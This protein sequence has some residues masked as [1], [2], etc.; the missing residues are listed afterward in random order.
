MLA[1]YGDIFEASLGLLV[2]DVHLETDPNVVPLRRLSVAIR[3]RV[4]AELTLMVNDEII[5]PVTEATRWVSAL[6][7]VSKPNEGLRI[8]L[9]PKPLNKALF[10]VH[11]TCLLSTTCC[12]IYLELV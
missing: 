4:K 9:D 10:V 6:L 3:D 7:V 2:G 1:Q 11:T 8:C 5:T 12:H